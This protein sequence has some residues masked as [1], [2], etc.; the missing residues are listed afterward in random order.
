[1]SCSGHLPVVAAAGL[2]LGYHGNPLL[3]DVVFDVK[4]GDVL[5]VVG[6]NG[7]GK[8]T[9]VKTLL[10][11]IPAVGG[12]LLWGRGRPEEIAYLGQLTEFDRC[13]PVR[14]RDLATMGAWHGLGFLGAITGERRRRVDEALVRCGI[15]E[16][17]DQPIHE[18]S[19]GQLQ[20]ALFART[21]VQDAPLILLDEPFTAVD[22][23]TEDKLLGLIDAWANEGRSVILVVHDLTAVLRHCN[24]ALLLGNGLCRY[25]APRDVL[26]PENLVEQGYM[27][28]GQADWM[29]TMYRDD[30]TEKSAPRR[31][32]ALRV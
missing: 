14:V 4:K 8:S 1:M 6:H 12:H 26:T 23:T 15:E 2:S 13:F 29:S 5:A 9:F 31:K 16:I 30:P 17:A 27:S 22:Q 3:D 20:R 7:S 25:G 21:I 18:L 28:A 10:G 32:E 11:V 24:K 19:S